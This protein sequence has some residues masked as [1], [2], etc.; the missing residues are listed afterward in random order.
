MLSRVMQTRAV[1]RVILLILLLSGAASAFLAYRLQEAHERLIA[2]HAAVAASLD[3]MAT[4]ITDMGLAQEAYVAPGQPDHTWVARVD[5]L[6]RQLVDASTA[7]RRDLRSADAARQLQTLSN[8][9][10]NLQQIDLRIRESLLN[11]DDFSAA[12]VIFTDARDAL[13]SMTDTVRTLEQGE[14]DAFTTERADLVLQGWRLVAATGALWTIGLLFL[15]RSPR[16]SVPAEPPARTTDSEA[17]GDQVD[18][19]L[20]GPASDAPAVAGAPASPEPTLDL[21]AAADVCTAI[22]RVKSSDAIPDLLARVASVLDAS[23]IIL[24]MGIEDELFAVTAFGYEPRLLAR[25]GPIGREANNATAETWR[26]GILGT[27]PGDMVSDGAIVAPMFGV[28]GCIGVL[29]AEIRHGR[30]S[31]PATRAVTAMFAA[32]LAT[33]VS[34]LPTASVESGNIDRG[35]DDPSDPLSASV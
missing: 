25:L 23:G 2:S 19:R 16:A 4:T 1:R 33:V 34:A 22:S 11:A 12:A 9:L 32:Q 18:L 24:W 15:A 14:T 7:V 26:T 27:V 3:A 29:A 5:E 31:D 6:G 30:E 28:D 17:S 21:A 8:T 13:T 35:N 10:D 20:D